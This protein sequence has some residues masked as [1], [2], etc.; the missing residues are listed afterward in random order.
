MKLVIV[1]SPTK[2]N[3]IGHYLG[4]DYIVE[5]SVGHIRDLA[6]SGKG[7]LGVDI[8]HDFKPNYIVNK[9]KY[10]VVKKLRELKDEA[11]EVIIATDPDREGEAIAWH[12]AEVL[13]L[14]VEST[15][16]LEFHE[17]TKSSI[18]NAIENPRNI[19]M[20]LVH[21]QEARRI[22]DRIIGFRLSSLLK[23]KIKSQSAG[24]VQSVTL[25]MIVE[26]EKEI[27][28]FVPEEFYAVKAATKIDGKDYEL[29]LAKFLN[30]ANKLPSK[31]VADEFLTH[32]KDKYSVTDVTKTNKTIS[33]KEPYRTSTLQQDAI[34]KLGLSS[35]E[36]TLLS[37]QLYEGVEIKGNMVGLITYI[38][39]DATN[40]SDSFV[41]EAKKLIVKRFGEDY[42]KGVKSQKVVK[43]A[44]M[45]H[46]AIR[47]T[48]LSLSLA[49][50]EPYLSEKQFKLYKLIYER[51]LASLMSDKQTEST[52]VKIENEDKTVAFD[53]KGSKVIYKGYSILREDE[54]E[55]P[56]LPEFAVGEPI[57]LSSLK[58]KQD[59][60][61]PPARYSEAKIINLM[62]EKGIGRPSTYSSTIQTLILRK[63]VTK[64]QGALK[65]T[66]QGVLT[67]NVLNKYF[68]DLM[69][70]SYTAEM[71]TQL[72]LIS[73]GDNDELKVI[74][75]F[76]EPFETHFEEVKEVM[77]KEPL[78]KTGEVCPVCGADLVIRK[79]KYG[80][81]I[82][83]SNYPTCNY[84]KKD[85]PEL[86][87]VGRE[88]PNC[89]SP[90]VYRFN[91][92]G[93]KFIGCS[94]FPK[95]KYIESV[96]L[97]TNEQY[98]ERICP[99]CGS[100]LIIKYS[101]G[102]PFYGCSNYPN[103]KHI[104]KVDKKWAK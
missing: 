78:K 2:S 42:Y 34:T 81:F 47:P 53:L 65:P 70:E 102:R 69:N 14:P 101:R 59:F 26:R 91:K 31:E 29:N 35:K 71:E 1:E 99:E 12:L 15:K 74:R 86:E 72:D 64:S 17:I 83:C 28:A 63:Y 33:S 100:P 21:S 25:K 96:T 67:S 6:I 8:D 76:Y 7:G 20:Y 32:K 54:E 51:T 30:H 89:G 46:E 77:Y 61:K 57:K 62:E 98:E 39:T 88:C 44:Q 95:C 82:G 104:E 3:T 87:E 23:S 66:E 27:K 52:N 43:G 103:C 18:K 60:T 73:S 92:R 45:A 84:I 19:D 5:A 56:T 94:N 85:K 68:P 4:D 75:D 90:L 40:L 36:V 16:R 93:E 97:R 48:D 11:E 24:R 55:A 10:E 41:K 13:E 80:D 49:D 38:R 37:Q 22:I 50:V 9:D 79:G 58:T